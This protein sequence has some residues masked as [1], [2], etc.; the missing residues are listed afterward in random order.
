MSGAEV[1]FERARGRLDDARFLLE[2]AR[3]EA[4]LSQIYLAVLYASRALL[5]RQELDVKTPASVVGNVG[6]FVEYRER[7]DTTLPLQLRDE[8]ERSV[9]ALEQFALEHVARRLREVER[10]VRSAGRLN[11]RRR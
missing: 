6:R 1:H 10:F 11:R 3:A 8:W 9:Y 5:A 2:S 4:A 7:L